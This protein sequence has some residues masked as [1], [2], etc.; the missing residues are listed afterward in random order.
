MEISRG[1]QGF[2]IIRNVSKD[3]VY[4]KLV[5]LVIKSI[6][7]SIVE[8]RLSNY[9]FIVPKHSSITVIIYIS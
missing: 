2:L 4:I 1:E 8:V 6:T 5:N 3:K 9:N 7:V